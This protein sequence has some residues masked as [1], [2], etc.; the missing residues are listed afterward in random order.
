MKRS[1][2]KWVAVALLL[3]VAMQTATSMPDDKPEPATA[4]KA[5]GSKAEAD[6]AATKNVASDNHYKFSER[7][8]EGYEPDREGGYPWIEGHK[9]Y[10]RHEGEGPDYY[11]GEGYKKY[12]GEYKPDYYRGDSHIDDGHYKHKHHG[13]YP[14]H[15][16]YPS[17]PPPPPPAVDVSNS[18]IHHPAQLNAC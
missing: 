6:S 17:P 2:V 11:Q 10:K 16:P 9:G 15:T 13:Y 12:D 14:K 7:E 8:Y 3:S 4:V 1:S 5:E 18:T